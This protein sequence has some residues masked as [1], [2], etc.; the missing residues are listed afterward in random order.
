MK[1]GAIFPT[2]EI[3]DDPAFIRDWT[4]AAEA[5]GYSHIVC[6][7]H[8]VGAEHRDRTPPLVGPYTEKDPFHEPF[9]VMAYMAALTTRIELASGVLIL[10]QRQTVLV[11]KQAAELQLLSQGRFR[12]GV[13][14]GWNHVEYDSLGEDFASRGPRLTEQVDLPR[15]P[16][17][18]PIWFGGFNDVAFRRAARVGDGFIFGSWPKRMEKMLIR[19]QTML[20]EYGR[21]EEDFGAE[22]LVDFTGDPDSW[23]EA[24]AFWEKIG[25]TRIAL[26]AMDTAAEFA[27]EKFHGYKGPKSYI[28][29][30]ETFMNEVGSLNSPG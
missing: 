28:D 15:P 10:P 12:M 17:K 23:T 6:Y 11:A 21:S 4:Q 26:R 30:L 8:V 9:V 1:I 19:V 7:D 13:G 24:I 29:A 14:T 25:G 16:S 5:L 22:A 2:C 18:I 27:G 3:G 20:E